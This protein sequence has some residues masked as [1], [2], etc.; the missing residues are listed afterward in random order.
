[1]LQ[2]SLSSLLDLA[3]DP[4]R[5][6]ILIAYDDDD[7][8]SHEFF[9]GND[10]SSFIST[11]PV[12]HK[13]FQVPR[14]GYSAL[15]Q[16]I[17]MLA[18]N[19]QG[20]WIFFWNDDSLMETK[21]WDDHIREN[22]DFLGLLHIT[23]SNMPMNCSIFPLLNRQWLDLFG[24]VS[25]INHADSWVSD[26]CWKA[27]ARRVIPVTAFHDRFETSG[28]NRDETYED[29]KNALANGSNA[30]YFTPESKKLREAWVE[31]LKIFRKNS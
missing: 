18:A 10:W 22:E 26:V 1:M 2:A 16:Y 7:V 6:E 5:I 4:K 27:Q 25:P 14:W 15:H 28:N 17:N 24:C 29:K 9:S 8:M 30:D 19:S 31:R 12:N 3:A 23:A 20:K 13:I 11:W 21:N